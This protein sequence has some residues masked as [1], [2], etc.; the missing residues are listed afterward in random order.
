MGTSNRDPRGPR[1]SSQDLDPLGVSHAIEKGQHHEGMDIAASHLG[2]IGG[3]GRDYGGM[4]MGI[5]FAIS[6]TVLGQTACYYV[7]RSAS[8]DKV[9]TLVAPC[10]GRGF[11]S[12]WCPACAWMSRW[13][14]PRYEVWARQ[15]GIAVVG[16]VVSPNGGIG[17]PGPYDA[18][19]AG[20]IHKAGVLSPSKMRA[21]LVRYSRQFHLQMPLGI[22]KGNTFVR[23]YDPGQSFPM[24]VFFNSQQQRLGWAAGIETESQ[25]VQATL[26]TYRWLIPSDNR[27][28]PSS[29]NKPPVRYDNN[30]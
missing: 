22:D 27:T 3:S 30:S 6:H 15:H 13:T 1:L 4:R 24:I 20:Q 28:R 17:V 19:G 11:F 7:D 18:P 16:I 25:L 12:T 10:C 29:W 2:T 26:A 21:L 23:R 8:S 14:L 5:V 9:I